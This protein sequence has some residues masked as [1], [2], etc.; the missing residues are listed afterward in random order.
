MLAARREREAENG[1]CRN[2][3]DAVI[4]AGPFDVAERSF[5]ERLQAIS[6]RK[7][8]GRRIGTL[9]MRS[10]TNTVNEMPTMSPT[11]GLD[12]EMRRQGGRPIGT[13]PTNAASHNVTPPIPSAAR[14]RWRRS[15]NPPCN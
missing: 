8:P 15:S 14:D 9:P 12:S 2:A 5:S 11:H 13:A 7:C 4:S 1:Q 6:G 3:V 10:A